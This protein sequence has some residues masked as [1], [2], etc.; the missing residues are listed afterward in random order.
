MYSYEWDPETH[1]F[2]LTT[3]SAKY[4]AYEI[5]PVF[6]QELNLAGM[7]SHFLYDKNET[8]PLMWAQ[9]NIYFVDG[10]KVA[11]L[12]NT[13]YGVE[14][15]IEFFFEGIKQLEPVDIDLMIAKNTPIMKI[16]IADTK[17]R[18]KELYDKNISRCDIAYV[19][20]SGGKDSLVLLDLCNQV[21]PSSAPVIFSDTD[22]ELPDTYSNWETVKSKYSDREFIR[23]IAEK[24]ALVNWQLFG[25]PS[26]GLR[27]CCPVHKSTPALITLKHKLFK[28]SI[29]VWR[30]LAYV[31]MKVMLDPYMRMGQMV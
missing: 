26:R 18:A 5:R 6:A 31:E 29:K 3:R 24:P 1:G 9:K 12:N 16:I 15:S 8:R 7:D 4:V 27:W 14:L 13:Q 25:P 20:F 2:I 22:M 21:L 30:S 10:E 28:D 23:A 11:K 17:R 19:A